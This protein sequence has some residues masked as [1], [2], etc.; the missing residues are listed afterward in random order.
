MATA[1]S[2]PRTCVSALGVLLGALAASALA[3]SSEP[4]SP[5]AANPKPTP[6][7]PAAHGAPPERQPIGQ[8]HDTGLSEPSAR[9]RRRLGTVRGM[10]IGPIE[11]TLHAG[12][13]YGSPAFEAALGTSRRLGANWI[14]LTPFGRVWDLRSTGIDLRFEA[15]AKDTALG[16]TR[17]VAQAHAR[18]LKV[19]LVP[20]LWVES[21][22][23]RGELDPGSDE[24]WDEWARAY[25]R[26]VLHWARIAQQSGVDLF[27]VG[28]ELRSWV[29]TTRAPSFSAIVDQVRRVYNGP[30]TYA[31]NWDDIEQTV[32]LGQLDL[33]GINAFY[34]LHHEENA[35][36]DQLLDGGRRVAERAAELSQAWGKPI[37]FTEIGYTNRAN[38][39]IRPWEWPDSM[40][41]VTLAPQQQAEAFAALLHE[42]TDEPWFAGFFVW[43]MYSDP[44]DCSQEAQWGF[45]PLYREAELV[46]RDAYATRWA[47]LEGLPRLL[48]T[49]PRAE[50]PAGF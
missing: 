23:W 47:G 41:D 13:G 34:P 27:S 45:S 19:M 40:T 5:T 46:L 9:L 11:S 22:E 33:I 15:P 20:H 43:R 8:L 42:L 25:E 14:S 12:R 18:G 30:I 3:N 49:A 48:F 7:A 35:R 17:A 44:F 29:T 1:L 6:S 32:I 50:N 37:L 21:G 10:T 4:S 24:A 26:F 28:V 38:P 39:A 36:F 2:R 31:G 16:I